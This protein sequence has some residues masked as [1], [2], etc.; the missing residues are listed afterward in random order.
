MLLRFKG[1]EASERRYGNCKGP[2]AVAPMFLQHNRRIAA[3][4]TV[5]C[6]ALLVFS[7]VERQV[8][9]QIA[10]AAKIPGLYARPARPAHRM[11]DLRCYGRAAA[12]P[13]CCGPGQRSSAAH[14]T[15]AATAGPARRRPAETSMIKVRR[16]S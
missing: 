1:Q 3:L 13:G 11:A 5:I 15:A 16:V 8:R 6:L 7:V 4:I 10:P 2:L 14:A 9:A 12:H